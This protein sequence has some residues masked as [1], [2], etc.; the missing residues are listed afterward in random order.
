MLKNKSS[1]EFTYS[2]E[3]LFKK[4]ISKKITIILKD[5]LLDSFV[6]KRIAKN[7]IMPIPINPEKT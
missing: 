2:I 4:L 5:L 6:N 7:N 3:S 1:N